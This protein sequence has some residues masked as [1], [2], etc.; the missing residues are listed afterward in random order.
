[1]QETWQ[2]KRLNSSIRRTSSLPSPRRG[3]SGRGRKSASSR[4]VRKER[5]WKRRGL[6]RHIDGLAQPTFTDV[7]GAVRSATSRSGGH[8][9]E[10]TQN[11]PLRR[12]DSTE[13]GLGCQRVCPPVR[14]LVGGR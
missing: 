1:M 8:R 3:G 14:E 11:P 9:H 12:P 13:S 6:R 5:S 10:N 4:R 7:A 2:K